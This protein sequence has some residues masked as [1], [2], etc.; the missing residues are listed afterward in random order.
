MQKLHDKLLNE[1]LLFE[2]PQPEP[3]VLAVNIRSLQLNKETWDFVLMV[4]SWIDSWLSGLWTDVNFDLMDLELK[5]FAKELR[6][7]HLKIESRF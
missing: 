7:M 6:G 5:R 3:N 4:K 2:V 1:A